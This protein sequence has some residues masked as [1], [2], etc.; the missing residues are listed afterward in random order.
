M[1]FNSVTMACV[2]NYFS[3]DK[4]VLFK[5]KIKTAIKYKDIELD[6]EGGLD[7]SVSLWGKTHISWM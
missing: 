3:V 6:H 5:E 2:Q 1:G 7:E 4:M